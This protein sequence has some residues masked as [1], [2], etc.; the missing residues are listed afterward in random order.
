MRT[1]TQKMENSLNHEK[2][3]NIQNEYDSQYLYRYIH[4]TSMHIFLLLWLLRIVQTV[5]CISKKIIL[6]RF[7]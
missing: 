6:F 5:S 2:I 4:M 7:K 1:N 3:C